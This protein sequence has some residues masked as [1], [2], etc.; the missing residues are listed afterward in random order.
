MNMRLL[1]L[2]LGVLLITFG[3]IS[4]E[5]KY[6]GFSFVPKN[7]SLSSGLLGIGISLIIILAVVGDMDL[8]KLNNTQRSIMEE[9]YMI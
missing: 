6:T 4:I 5:P 7:F 2:I 9:N 8:K 1:L 3:L